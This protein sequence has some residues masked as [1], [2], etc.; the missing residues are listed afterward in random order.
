MDVRERGRRQPPSPIER[1]R[2]YSM[3]ALLLD[4]GRLG[5]GG[6]SAVA[7]VVGGWNRG[8]EGISC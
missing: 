7:A 1:V 6:P 4:G 5:N 2:D 8:A 3:L